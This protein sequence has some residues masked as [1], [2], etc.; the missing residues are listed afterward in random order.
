MFGYIGVCPLINVYF[1]HQSSTVEPP[2]S[3]H[4]WGIV[5]WPLNEGWPLNRNKLA[6][7]LAK[8]SLFF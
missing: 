7:S 8:R 4:P 6:K 3:G 2:L 5:K 1:L